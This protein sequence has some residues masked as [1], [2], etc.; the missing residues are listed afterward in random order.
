MSG[1]SQA[2]SGYGLELQKGTGVFS[3]SPA[4]E[5]F[6][7]IAEI[8]Q[9]AFTG[10]KVDLADVTNVASPNRRREYIA[11]LIDSGELT[12]TANFIPGDSTQAG[13]RTTMDAAEAVN[14]QVVL[15]NSL[16]TLSFAGI[17]TSLDRNL[18]F[19]KE[20]KLSAKIKITGPITEVYS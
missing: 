3:G 7:T 11:T 4:V 16:G 6:D 14:W 17:L 20:A 18:D 19:S 10:S 5:T 8:Q 9:V 2:F 13:L 12:F 1:P 15:P